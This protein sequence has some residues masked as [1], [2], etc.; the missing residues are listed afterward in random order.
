MVVKVQND[1][2][3]GG[4][5]GDAEEG[6][7]QHTDPASC[8]AINSACPE[9]AGDQEVVGWQQGGGKEVVLIANKL[10]RLRLPHF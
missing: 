6:M 1:A 8:A 5:R 2:R 4:E 3:A 10:T 9:G 7:Q